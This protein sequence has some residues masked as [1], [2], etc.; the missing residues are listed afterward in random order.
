MGWKGQEVKR[1]NN[2]LRQ[3]R[4]VKFL[5]GRKELAG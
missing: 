2:L 5:F 1:W 4:A 3:G